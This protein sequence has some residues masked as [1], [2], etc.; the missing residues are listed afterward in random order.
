[1]SLLTIL[2]YFAGGWVWQVGSCGSALSDEERAQIVEATRTETA[3]GAR[4]TRFFEEPYEL[5]TGKPEEAARGLEDRMRKDKASLYARI[6]NADGIE[7]EA[8]E[9]AVG[10]PEDGEEI[11]EI[12]NYVLNQKTSEK[13]YPNGTRDKGRNGVR[14]AYFI[15]HSCARDADLSEGE[16][17]SL[18]IY[19]TF[20]YKTMNNPLR[21]DERYARRVPVPL[22]A[23]SKMADDAIRKLRALRAKAGAAGRN[24]VVWR[25]MRDLR[26]SEAFMREGG[27]ELGFMSTTTDLR[28]AVRYSLSRHS[29]L[30][31]MVAPN[32]MSLGAELQWLSAFPNEAEVLFP[33]LTF[34]QP[35]GRMDRVDAVDRDGNPVTFTVVE[36]TPSF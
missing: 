4:G 36:V 31:K 3:V 5:K 14:P 9:Y 28:V 13:E 23:I 2:I 32:F 25:G 1:M 34:L 7:Q 19:T 21:D 35:T 27:T 18:R 16:V 20:V 22:P 12:V 29:L 6:T 33:P 30:F 17:L 15:S 24:S 10:S 8:Q 26:V 11:V